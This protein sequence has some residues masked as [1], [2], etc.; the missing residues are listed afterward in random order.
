MKRN[1]F[2]IVALAACALALTACGGAKMATAEQMNGEWD[3]QEINGKPLVMT[4]GQRPFIGFDAKEGRVYG[5][6]GCNRLM[7]PFDAKTGKLDFTHMGSTMMA[8]PNMDMERDVL[9]AL[10][11]AKEFMLGKNGM[12]SLRDASGKSVVTLRRRLEVKDFA[13]LQGDWRV[14]SVN[15]K[16]VDEKAESVPVL[17][18]DVKEMRFSGTTGCNKLMGKLTREADDTRS[19]GFSLTATTRM[20]CP[21]MTLERDI[22]AALGEVRSFGQLPD[23]HVGL[24]TEGGMVAFELVPTR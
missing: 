22:L 18:F 1:K 11:Q 7:A 8:G 23:G 21:D 5:Y 3:I 12:A 6:G 14:V 20:A 13:A 24:F 4:E 15:G 10:G 9:A 19:L 2:R 16:A 17:S